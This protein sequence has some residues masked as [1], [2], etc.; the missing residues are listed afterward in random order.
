ME[1]DTVPLGGW[2]LIWYI[3]ILMLLLFLSA[4]VSG[5]EVAFFQLKEK[6]RTGED[7]S[8]R[9]SIDKLLKS[10]QKLL[11]TILVANNFINITI[12]VLATYLV[13]RLVKDMSPMT[14]FLIEVVLIT[15]VILFFGEILPK[16][17]A[18]RN[19]LAF[20][21][22]TA[23][24]MKFFQK[25][26][27][28]LIVPMVKITGRLEKHLRAEHQLFSRED[29][30]K[31]FE[32]T[33]DEATQDERRILSGILRFG[34]TE[35]KQIM[36][37]RLDI[38]ALSDEEDFPSII[39]KIKEK[40]FSRIPV[41]HGDLDHIR[42]ILFAKDLLPYLDKPRFDWT[43]LIRPAFFV[44]ENIKL[45]DLLRDFRNKR[46]HLAIVVDEY[47]GTSGLVTLEDVIE[48]VL[49]EEIRD[50]HDRETLPYKKTGKNAYLFEGKTPLKD[51]YKY[52][53]LDEGTV[54]KFEEA[55]GP[56]ESLAGFLLELNGVF[57]SVDD[58][59]RFDGFEFTVKELDKNRI[60]KILVKKTA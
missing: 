53:N 6:P 17:L 38:F 23:P 12:V 28:F 25:L 9:K 13:S 52:L 16:V 50:E 42:G 8:A 46:M 39:R 44:P 30:S 22:R 49:G 4:L 40:G 18:T 33:R 45:D 26:F 56:S 54:E 41:Y 60:D 24:L 10:P 48:E 35:A 19:D 37:P 58:R 21:R 47:G 7:E 59:I 3:L 57:P 36:K 27:Y 32:L 5:S 51:F 55:K 11:A 43:R 29:L 15:S 1:S 20:A 31:V 34:D 2:H 14:E